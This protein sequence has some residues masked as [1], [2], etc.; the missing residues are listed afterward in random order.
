[1]TTFVKPED[2]VP[3][4]LE[5]T[6]AASIRTRPVQWLWEGWL[7]LGKVA[8]LDGRPGLGKSSM[9]L[10]VAARTTTGRQMPDGFD[11]GLGPRDVLVV[12]AE[13]DWED[14]VVPRLV[15]AG[16]D[17]TRVH[18]VEDL[19]LPADCGRL[20]TAIEL[21]AAVLVVFDPV[22]AF[23]PAKF[24]LYKDQSARLVLKP[25]GLVAAAT[26]C[27]VLCLR[28]VNKATGQSAQDRGT[29]SVAIGGAA[30]VNLIAGPDPDVDGQYVLAPIKVNVGT[31]HAP[32]GYRIDSRNVPTDEGSAA[33]VPVLAWLGDVDVTAD[34]LVTVGRQGEAT[35]FLR[36]ALRDGPVA[37][38]ELEKQAKNEGLSWTGAVRRASER[39]PV[40]KSPSGFGGEWQWSLPSSRERS[41]PYNTAQDRPDGSTSVVQN[42][43]EMSRDKQS[44]MTPPVATNGGHP[45]GRDAAAAGFAN[46]LDESS[47]G[48]WSKLDGKPPA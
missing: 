11:P 42:D 1:M 23:V 8:M 5:L 33:S 44:S 39:I 10:D 17:L 48:M 3:V 2:L 27:A 41:S 6:P 30:R 16:A 45:S 26:R 25:L 36:N 34:D 12:T 37:A 20:R 28:H 14:T 22:V 43:S 21:V 4:V 24:D 19:D 47:G 9:A 35:T 13:D 18:R 7:P 15:A 32:L 38:K 29:G 46:Y 40:V 31:K